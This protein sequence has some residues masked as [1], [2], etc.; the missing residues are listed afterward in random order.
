MEKYLSLPSRPTVINYGI[1]TDDRTQP[2]VK[3]IITNVKRPTSTS[4]N[5]DGAE[6][7]DL[8]DNLEDNTEPALPE[9]NTS[10]GG[11]HKL[12][13]KNSY[14]KVS[15]DDEEGPRGTNTTPGDDVGM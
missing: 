6:E 5:H 1:V 15:E 2:K 3:K 14:K 9:R 10:G 13:K 7:D 8:E 4:T 12:E 11:T